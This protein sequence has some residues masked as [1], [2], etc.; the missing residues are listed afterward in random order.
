MQFLIPEIG[1]KVTLAEDWEFVLCDEHRNQ[2]ATDLLTRK[3]IKQP[4]THEEVMEILE[5]NAK[6]N[7]NDHKKRIAVLKFQYDQATKNPKEYM[8]W[9]PQFVEWVGRSDGRWGRE[10]HTFTSEPE[11]L[12]FLCKKWIDCKDRLTTIDQAL[13]EEKEL[14]YDYWL[15]GNDRPDAGTTVLPKDSELTVDRIYIRKGA[16][17]FSSI[18]FYLNSFGGKPLKEVLHFGKK[19]STIRF[20]AKLEDVNNI[21]ISKYV[22]KK[23]KKIFTDEQTGTN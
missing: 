13:K 23:T 19:V 20:W 21:R 14:H 6:S 2:A 11:M 17:E 12:Q 22:Q 15:N 7:L 1:D 9:N 8:R 4:R 18:T 16:S 5:R 3:M 10:V